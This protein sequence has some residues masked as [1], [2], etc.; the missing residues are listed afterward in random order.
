MLEKLW[1]ALENF[2]FKEASSEEVPDKTQAVGSWRE[3]GEQVVICDPVGEFWIGR[4]PIAWAE[5][6]NLMN[7]YGMPQLDKR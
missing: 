1:C 3:V 2:G 5:F 7:S 6:K 4:K